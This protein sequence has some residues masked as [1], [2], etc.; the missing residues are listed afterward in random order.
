MG[1]PH[2]V[3]TRIVK[4]ISFGFLDPGYNKN[5]D[6]TFS[7]VFTINGLADGPLTVDNTVVVGVGDGA[8]AGDLGPDDPRL[9]G[10]RRWPAQQPPSP[11]PTPGVD[12]LDQPTE[13]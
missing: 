1:R 2:P 5:L 10:R 8:G 13:P 12:R 9:R 11:E 6:D 4:K 7:I 3:A